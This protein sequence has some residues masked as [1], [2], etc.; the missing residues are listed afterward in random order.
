MPVARP[1]RQPVV[2]RYG[3][4]GHKTV[5]TTTMTTTAMIKL[6]IESQFSFSSLSSNVSIGGSSSN[7]PL[8]LRYSMV[9][10]FCLHSARFSANRMAQVAAI[11]H[12]TRF[13]GTKSAA[14]SR[15]AAV[16]HR[17]ASAAAAAATKRRPAGRPICLFCLYSELSTQHYL[18]SLL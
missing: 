8:W 1:F 7:K 18:L 4:H 12:K 2:S 3:R 13:A 11:R 10:I 17:P 6:R 14:P 16:I 9:K 5:T 15:V